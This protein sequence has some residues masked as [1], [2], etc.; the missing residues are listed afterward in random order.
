MIKEIYYVEMYAR[1]LI[2][3]PSLFSQ[4]KM[5]IDSQLQGSR[6]LFRNMFSG[7]YKENARRYLRGRGI[8]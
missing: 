6:S 3:D 8:L 5:L 7:N 2:E 1:K 4:Q